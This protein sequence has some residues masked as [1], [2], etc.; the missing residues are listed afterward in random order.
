M[1]AVKNFTQWARGFF[2]QDAP[3]SMTRLIILLSFVVGTILAF[4]KYPFGVVSLFIVQGAFATA[5]RTQNHNG[6]E[7]L[8]PGMVKTETTT[9]AT[10]AT[11]V[12][13]TKAPKSKG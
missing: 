8:V 3:P 4:C 2:E 13:A 5:F 6:K 9:A 10:S 11:T 12:T 7:P 1:T